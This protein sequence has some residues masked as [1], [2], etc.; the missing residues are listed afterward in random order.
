MSLRIEEWG[1]DGVK[2]RSCATS[3]AREHQLE[4]SLVQGGG[5]A[6]PVVLVLVLFVCA[7]AFAFESAFAFAFSHPMILHASS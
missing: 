6:T 3:L 1:M 2:C 5:K 7:F 4:H